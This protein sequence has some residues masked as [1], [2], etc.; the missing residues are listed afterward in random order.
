MYASVSMRDAA[1]AVHELVHGDVIGRVWSAALHIDDGRVSEAH[2]MISLREGELHMITLR[3]PLAV[4]GRPMTRVVLTPGVVVHLA[5]GLPLEVISVQLP[6]SVLAIEGPGLTRQALPGVCSIVL[7]PGAARLMSGWRDDAVAQ[8]WSTGESWRARAPDG[9]LRDLGPGDTLQAGPHVLRLVPM[10]L[11]AAGLPAT[12]R[13]GEIDAPL[14]VI[15]QF[16]NVH[17]QRAGETTVVLPGKQ[18]QLVSE[19]VACGG[20]LAWG[21]LAAE[22]WPEATEDPTRR[23]RLDA[24]LSK[25]RRRLRAASIREDLVR[26]DGA[27]QVELLLHAHDTLIDRT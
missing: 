22:L 12:R 11:M 24:L 4:G 23:V 19:L 5:R 18:G 20:P 26:T 8:L 6:E 3:G 25:L 15:A 10:T 7:E 27:G 14:T 16:D 21:A 1:G 13:A 2:A 17:I 9:A